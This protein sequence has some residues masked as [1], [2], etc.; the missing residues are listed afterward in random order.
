[1]YRGAILNSDIN[2]IA[3]NL[4]HTDQLC[5]ADCGLPIPPQTEKVDLA[6]KP[7]TPGFWEVLTEVSDH[8]EVERITLAEEI[9]EYNAPLYQ[10]LCERFQDIP[11]EL[12]PHEA[13][14]QQTA[15]CAAV[16]RTGEVRPYAN[17]ILH[18]GCLF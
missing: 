4:G 9:R 17:I 18:S 2:R 15:H 5:I 14:K 7:G 1:M 16:I 8:L 12:I 11:M 6:L 3:G 13:F 10:M